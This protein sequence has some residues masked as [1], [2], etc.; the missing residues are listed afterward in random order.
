MFNKKIKSFIFNCKY[1]L[2]TFIIFFQLFF[3]SISYS[4]TITLPSNSFPSTDDE[5]FDQENKNMV[6]PLVFTLRIKNQPVVKFYMEKKPQLI[7]KQ[8]QY[9][10]TLL[11]HAIGYHC[12]DIVQHLINDR[13]VDVFMPNKSGVTPLMIAAQ[14]NNS[15][16]IDFIQNSKPDQ[17][18]AGVEM[19]DNNG[20]TALHYACQY[21]HMNAIKKLVNINNQLVNSQ[22]HNDDTPLLYALK[23]NL[24]NHESINF[25]LDVEVLDISKADN[26]GFHF[27][28]WVAKQNKT[29][30]FEK[31]LDRPELKQAL[32][33]KNENLE[34]C[35]FQCINVS[36]EGDHG[37]SIDVLKQMLKAS[38]N[39]VNSTTKAG[40]PLIMLA[41][42]YKKWAVFKLL[43]DMGANIALPNNNGVTV[44]MLLTHHNALKQLQMLQDNPNFKR[45]VNKQDNDRQ[46]ALFY[47]GSEKYCIR[48]YELSRIG[49]VALAGNFL[50]KQ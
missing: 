10:S 19:R 30:L 36:Q 16:A 17:I 9:G 37:D 4:L 22:A 15:D 26:N 2:L 12:N 46:N 7:D 45:C 24:I 44:I 41:A 14:Y 18:K 28:S 38:P 43:L 39:L 29:T 13:N 40:E 8:D 48:F 6:S 35:L 1:Y 20:L 27:I 5:L 33:L 21:G 11:H 3:S 23:N 31:V 34:N 42:N 25:L 47:I 49:A 50:G 32:S